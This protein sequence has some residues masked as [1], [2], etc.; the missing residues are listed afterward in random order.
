M[1]YIQFFRDVNYF[2][3]TFNWG[4]GLLQY[5]ILAQKVYLCILDRH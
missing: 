2:L 1:S 5:S 4:S 3:E